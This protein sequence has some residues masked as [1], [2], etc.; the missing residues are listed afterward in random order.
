MQP[1]LLCRFLIA[2][3]LVVAARAGVITNVTVLEVSSEYAP[4]RRHATNL[5]NGVGL[6][7]EIHTPLP[8]GTMWLTQLDAAG[9]VAQAYVVF[10]LGATYTLNKLKVWNY[11]EQASGANILTRRG[12]A[13][14]DILVAG[15]D[16][17]FTT[18]KAAQA[19]TRA[20]GVFTNFFDLID[21]GGVQARYVRINVLTN[22]GGDNRV[23]LSEV[24]FIANSVA[25]D[26]R[27][28]NR[29]FSGD[30]VI[31]QFSEAMDPASATNAAN[32]SITGPSGVVS[33]SSVDFHFYKDAVVLRPATALKTNEVYML[34]VQNVADANNSG[35]V[36]NE[37]LTILSDLAVWLKADQGVTAEGG[38]VS[39]WADQTGGD[40]A[41]QPDPAFQ[42]TLVENAVANKPAVHFNGVDQV[43]EIPYADSI[44]MDRDI[45][46]YLVLSF[47]FANSYRYHGPIGIN[48]NNVPASFDL[49]VDRGNPIGNNPKFTFL[50]GNGSGNQAFASQTGP[51]PNQFYVY[52]LVMRGTNATTYLNGS[53]NGTANILQGLWTVGNAIRLGMRQDGVT[54]FEGNLAE[55]MIFRG[56]VSDAERSAIDNYLGTKYGISVVALQITQQPEGATIEAGQRATFAVRA[57]AGTP[58]VNYQWQSNNVNIVGATNAYYTTPFLTKTPDTINY[59][60]VVSTP[61]GVTATSSN[62]IVNVTAYATGVTIASATRSTNDSQIVVT[63][64]EPVTA[65]ATQTSNYTLDRGATVSSAVAGSGPH[66]VVLTVSGLTTKVHYLSVKDVQGFGGQVMTPFTVPVLP[67]GVALWLR[68]DTGLQLENGFVRRW[69]DQGPNGNDAV[70]FNASARPPISAGNAAIN[71]RTTI[72]FSGAQFL[73]VFSNPSLV[74]TGDVSIFAVVNVADYAGFRGIVA[75][76]AG[77]QPAPLDYYL[78]QGSGL[79]RVYRG[80]GAGLNASTTGSVAPAAG[81]P[82]VVSL[83]QQGTSVTHYLDG[84]ENGTATLST[85]MAD[86]GTPL[87]IG[88]RDDLAVPFAG[89]IAEILIVNGPVSTAERQAIDTHLGIKYF[90]FSIVEQ[91]QPVA[92]QEG[93]TATFAVNARAGGAVFN[94]QWQRNNVV[95]PGANGATYTTP[96]LALANNNDTYRVM[97]SAPGFGTATSDAATLTVVPDQEAPTVVSVGRSISDPSQIVVVFSEPVSIQPSN[98]TINNGATITSAAAGTGATANEV[99]LMTTGLTQGG[100]FDLTVQNVKDLFNNTIATVTTAVRV[101]PASLALW[102]RADAGVTKDAQNFVSVWN[103]Q[104]GNANNVSSVALDNSPLFTTNVWDD[105]PSALFDGVDDYMV[106]PTSATLAIIGDMTVYVVA[107]FDSFD[108]FHGLVGKTAGAD[109]NIPA[110]FDYYV[111]PA[112]I[113]TFLRGD[114]AVSAGVPAQ[115]SV[116]AGEP[117]VLSVTMQGTAVKH[118]LDAAPN[119]FGVLNTTVDDAGTGFAVGTRNDLFTKM[120]GE[121]Q[122]IL[123]FASALS[124]RERAEIDEYLAEKYTAANPIA[125]ELSVTASAGNVQLSWNETTGFVLQHNSNISNA[126][127]WTDVTAPVVNA[128]G[129]NTVSVPIGSGSDFFR[130]IKP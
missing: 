83:V 43:L 44:V 21:M 26:V 81:E 58:T 93:Q 75:K 30:R 76:T 13:S 16:Q 45:T 90:P 85:T 15:E 29:S 104:S 52:S 82:H 9:A 117:H 46:L 98:F 92:R 79:P 7:G 22:F 41:V 112:G 77:N 106:A 28:A 103:D 3:A 48:N 53:F 110:P 86:A 57:V 108:G 115:T 74:L 109:N 51:Q 59:R 31:V 54:R 11:N 5:V 94:Y 113:P 10:D 116:A 56:A 49:Y 121:I 37:V 125:P 62:A 102:L 78:V 35:M 38:L 69:A 47:D 91:P 23:G 39:V 34:G 12:V 4:D 19:F 71:G 72:S 55:A 50:R 100:A 65:A 87:R 1:K 126:T 122:E 89:E 70:Q 24:Q 42:P 101:H 64:S 66:Q 36:G 63:F 97:I 80:N 130:L 61:L 114:G 111:T 99:V 95:I 119:G 20:P 123:I 6:F 17:A 68:A 67:S 60:V 14:A 40:D 118:Y 18:A 96:T 2:L 88:N 73:E 8:A 105:L 128:N 27:A 127:G 124:D 120:N 84:A 33:I 107:Q 32:Y 25:P 129:V